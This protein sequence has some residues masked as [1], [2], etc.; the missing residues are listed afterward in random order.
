[1]GRK[2]EDEQDLYDYLESKIPDANGLNWIP[3]L[4]ER[5]A[6]LLPAPPHPPHPLSPSSPPLSWIYHPL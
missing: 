4:L 6:D 1:M 5:F 2:V 3:G